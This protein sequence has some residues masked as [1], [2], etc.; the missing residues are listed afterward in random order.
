MTSGELRPL[1]T[2]IPDPE[3]TH[4]GSGPDTIPE[5]AKPKVQQM[6]QERS[7]SISRDRFR[8]GSWSQ[9]SGFA[10]PQDQNPLIP[11]PDTLR[12]FRDSGILSGLRVPSGSGP[13]PSQI[14]ILISNVRYIL[15]SLRPS[16]ES[17]KGPRGYKQ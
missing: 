2:R 12:V 7:S 16:S 1:N 17:Q 4:C 9:V 3:Q 11:D 14:A 10:D 5:H 15:H 8:S 13:P 6:V